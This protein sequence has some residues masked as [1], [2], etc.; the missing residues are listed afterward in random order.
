MSCVVVIGAGGHARSVINLIQSTQQSVWGVY[1]DHYVPGEKILSVPVLGKISDIKPEQKL[2]LAIGDNYHR[3]DAFFKFKSQIETESFI[4]PAAFV[5]SGVKMGIANQILAR[6]Y[7]NTQVII[8][9]NNLLNT[10]CVLEHE[11]EIGHH[12]HISVGAILCGRVKLGSL[13]FI[14]AGAVLADGICVCDDVIIGANSTVLNDISEPGTYVGS[15]ARK[16]K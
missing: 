3:A 11:V 1:D 14:G 16:V 9:D 12:N 7:L 5:E 10:A 6:A 8:G 4:H 15:P 13:C 2:V